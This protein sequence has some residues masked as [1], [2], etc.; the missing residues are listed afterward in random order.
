MSPLTGC[1]ASSVSPSQVMQLVAAVMGADSGPMTYETFARVV[2]S[3]ACAKFPGREADAAVNLLLE[4][5]VVPWATRSTGG[6]DLGAIYDEA[7]TCARGGSAASGCGVL[8][9]RRARRL[10]AVVRV[11]EVYEVPLQQ[12]FA[13]YSRSEAV[14]GQMVPTSKRTWEQVCKFQQQMR[15]GEFVEL[16]EAFGVLPTLCSRAA[17]SRFFAESSQKPASSSAHVKLTFAEFCECMVRLGM[18]ASGDAGVI[19][20][21]DG[22]KRVEQL[23]TTLGLHRRDRY[24]NTLQ[25]RHR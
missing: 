6:A 13:A 20:P 7:G 14:E 19:G 1:V 22:A 23:F 15:F 9:P 21:G 17:L 4:N 11:L 2:M 16:C 25:L 8:T 12:L 24:V 3:I 5:H 10:R 18:H